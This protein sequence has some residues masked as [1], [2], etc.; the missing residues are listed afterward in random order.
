MPLLFSLLVQG[1]LKKIWVCSLR[2]P[3]E[4]DQM[5]EGRINWRRE[6]S[7][8]TKSQPFSTYRG[9]AG[10]GFDSLVGSVLTGQGEIVSN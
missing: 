1:I 3:G 2:F 5:K 4:K 7:G 6:G 8:K 10:K 9:G